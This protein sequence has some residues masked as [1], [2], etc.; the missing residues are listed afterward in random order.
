MKK[1]PQSLVWFGVHFHWSM[2]GT[3]WLAGKKS[4]VRVTPYSKEP[5]DYYTVMVADV[6]KRF[7]PPESKSNAF[8]WA[9]EK[10]KESDAT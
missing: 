10:V 7:N 4:Q 3:C 9:A 1:R 5:N 8:Q 6:H 2:R